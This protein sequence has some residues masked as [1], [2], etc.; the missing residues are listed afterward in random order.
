MGNNYDATKNWIEAVLAEV[1]ILYANDGIQMT[2]KNLKI[3]TTQDPY[4]VGS[5]Y[6]KLMMF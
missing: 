3:W 1:F 5:T 2:L 4:P 6:D